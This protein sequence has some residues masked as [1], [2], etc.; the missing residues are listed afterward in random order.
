MCALACSS[1]KSQHHGF[2]SCRRSKHS[3]RSQ[4]HGRVLFGTPTTFQTTT[5][6][7]VTGE[8]F[9]LAPFAKVEFLGPKQHEYQREDATL[10]CT[11][12]KNGAQPGRVLV[13]TSTVCTQ[14]TRV[15]WKA[16]L[17]ATFQTTL[18]AVASERRHSK[19]F[20]C[21]KTHCFVAARIAGSCLSPGLIRRDS[22]RSCV[23]GAV[24]AQ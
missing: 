22:P 9:D 2:V 16:V 20:T 10:R 4:D 7:S 5:R 23:H 6:W 1:N 18:V 3:N 14:D 12:R 17:H 15:K 11:T 21:F 13:G 24:T 8:V 19:S